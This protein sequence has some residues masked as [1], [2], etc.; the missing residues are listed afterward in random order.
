MHERCPHLKRLVMPCWD[1]I[2]ETAMSDAINNWRELE[3][4]T[5]P[6]LTSSFRTMLTADGFCERLSQ[7]KI[8]GV[9]HDGFLS[10]PFGIYP[11][12]LKVLSLR[13]CLV[14]LG[15][16]LVVMDRYLH[17]EVLNLSHVLVSLDEH[18]EPM[19]L[20][21]LFGNAVGMSILERAFRLRSF[22]YC[23]DYETCSECKRMMDGHTWQTDGWWRLDEVAS[24]NLDDDHN[25][26]SS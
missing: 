15:G 6:S 24:L 21:K 26:I 16:L 1:S 12:E 5:M 23:D 22:F 13:C 9:V 18:M 25:Y 8:V 2:S 3:S 19:P 14:P 20:M 17:L 10:S 7:L 4:M 11:F